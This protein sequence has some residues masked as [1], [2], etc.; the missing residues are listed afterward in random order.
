MRPPFWCKQNWNWFSKLEL[1]LSHIRERKTEKTGS[2]HEKTL[3]RPIFCNSGVTTHLKWSPFLHCFC[4]FSLHRWWQT[5]VRGRATE[6]KRQKYSRMSTLCCHG[7]V[8]YFEA[9]WTDEFGHVVAPV[10]G[11]LLVRCCA[12]ASE[13]RHFFSSLSRFHHQ[14]QPSPW[15]RHR[16]LVLF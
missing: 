2:L 13:H 9:N 12:K 11:V 7:T 16:V 15:R 6:N 1:F 8:E 5:R 14:H 4:L 10:R 3:A